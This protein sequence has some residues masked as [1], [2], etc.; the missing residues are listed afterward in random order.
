M[1]SD[2]LRS[3]SETLHG[4]GRLVRQARAAAALTQEQVAERAGIS[5][6]RARDVE[7]GGGRRLRRDAHE[8]RALALAAAIGMDVPAR[9]LVARPDFEGL[10]QEFDTL[11]EDRG[12]GAVP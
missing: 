10:P 6:Q 8:H 2:S 7:E 12:R 11:A 1:R 9:E 4:I 3:E 5:R